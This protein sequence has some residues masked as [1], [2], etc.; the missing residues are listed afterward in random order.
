MPA[1]KPILFFDGH[2]NL[3]NRS[4]QF[5]LK[6]D[7]NGNVLMAPLQ[8]QTAQKL[9]GDKYVGDS[10]PPSIVLYDRGKVYTESTAVIKAAA[11]TGSP[12]RFSHFL[13]AVPAGIRNA[14]YRFI[15]RNRYRWF[16]RSDTCLLPKPA[17]KARF[18][19]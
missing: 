19:E 12:L 6:H 3:C 13:L 2:C 17:Y 10:A 15:A 5:F 18:L 4:V 1:D 7:P 14:L 16:G 9:L 8:G 11:Y